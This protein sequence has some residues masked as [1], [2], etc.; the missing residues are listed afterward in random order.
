MREQKETW[1]HIALRIRYEAA[2]SIFK[3]RSSP[4]DICVNKSCEWKGVSWS[5]HF[6]GYRAPC[7][8]E[9]HLI[10]LLFFSVMRKF[11]KVPESQVIL[12]ANVTAVGRSK[13]PG[14]E[15][16]LLQC[17]TGKGWWG[18]GRT[19]SSARLTLARLIKKN[20]WIP[21]EKLHFIGTLGDGH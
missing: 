15:S 4:G 5:G 7:F 8:L 21:D 17:L 14:S 1:L 9:S 19:Q 10:N 20:H 12:S 2:G 3:R 11:E 6:S 18:G 16:P 13:V